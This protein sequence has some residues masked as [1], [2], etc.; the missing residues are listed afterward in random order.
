M[1][2]FE[3]RLV[4]VNFARKLRVVA[5]RAERK[6]TPREHTR[7]TDLAE[8]VHRKVCVEG[9][10]WA[11]VMEALGKAQQSAVDVSIM[12]GLDDEPTNPSTPLAKRLLPRWWPF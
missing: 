3:R 10:S 5:V 12:D 11:E 9:C 6:L 2:Q 7:F 4:D 8:L 1:N